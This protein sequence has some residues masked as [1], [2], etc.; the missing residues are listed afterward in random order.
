MS[1]LRLYGKYLAVL[2][3]A[4]TQYPASFLML[5]AAT[6]LASGI[7]LLG[8][9]ALFARFDQIVGWA[10]PEV[11][12]IYGIIKMAFALGEGLGRGFDQFAAQV[13][14]GDFDLVLLRPRSTALQV[15]GQEAHLI[16]AGAFLQAGVVLGWAFAY[17]DLDLS[18]ERLALTAFAITGG[19][20]MFFGL[21][22]LQATLAFWTTETLE[23]MNMLTYGGCDLGQYPVTIY[24]SWFRRFFTFLV[25][26]ACI[27]Y[28]PVHAIVGKEE[29]FFCAPSGIGWITPTAGI[30]FLFVS[31]AIWNLGVR[32][33]RS[34]GS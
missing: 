32:H 6:F 31:L 33:Y 12:V 9:V 25:P 17:L 16:R 28:F 34:T 30:G 22:V 18:P 24:P 19:A 13:K 3:K 7:D 23:V 29:M 10:L 8:I 4:K 27:T 2:I 21:F 5:C 1:G 11:A 26:I 15:A 20:C 14:S